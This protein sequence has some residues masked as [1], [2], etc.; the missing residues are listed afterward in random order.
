MISSQ[1][2]KT[3]PLALGGQNRSR[4]LTWA[5]KQEKSPVVGGVFFL[6]VFPYRTDR[7]IEGKMFLTTGQFATYLKAGKG[8]YGLTREILVG[9]TILKGD[10][11]PFGGRT[12]S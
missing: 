9:A 5:A 1:N 3:G 7:E 12:V 6:D 4:S 2:T 11:P 8:S 10:R